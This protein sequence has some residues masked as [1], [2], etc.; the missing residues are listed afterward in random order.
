M[1]QEPLTVSVDLSRRSHC[2]RLFKLL[3]IS[4]FRQVFLG[5]T[6]LHPAAGFWTMQSL[7]RTC[8]VQRPQASRGQLASSGGSPSRVLQ[9]RH[10]CRRSVI[11]HAYVLQPSGAFAHAHPFAECHPRAVVPS[12]CLACA[13][14]AR[15]V[16]SPLSHAKIVYAQV[17]EIV[18]T[19]RRRSQLQAASSWK[20]APGSWEG[21]PCCG[22]LL[23]STCLLVQW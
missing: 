11:L 1:W 16:P 23:L 12:I 13:L 3:L 15:H 2:L 14:P 9:N 4:K 22:H 17:M 21:V 7:I 10:T 18:T 6:S 20:R 5:H 19:W 8:S